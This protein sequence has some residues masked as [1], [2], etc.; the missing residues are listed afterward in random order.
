MQLNNVEGYVLPA[1]FI[2]KDF[3]RPGPDANSDFRSPGSDHGY[4]MIVST[5]RQGSSAATQ[6]CIP[7]C[8]CQSFGPIAL[9]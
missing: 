8:Y 3:E 6:G 9:V 2:G 4:M 5:G 1:G 7:F